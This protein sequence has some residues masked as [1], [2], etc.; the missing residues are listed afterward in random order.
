MPD[1]VKDWISDGTPE[2]EPVTV[3]TPA[4]A[5]APELSTSDVDNVENTGATKE[6]VDETVVDTPVV[7]DAAA[8]IEMIAGKLG[9]EAYEI[10]AT[11]TIPL[12]HGDEIT[13]VSVADLQTGNMKDVDYR[14]KTQAI[15]DQRRELEAN[16]RQMAIDLARLRSDQAFVD[17]QTKEMKEAQ[18]DPTKWDAYQ[19]HL[20]MIGENPRYAKTFTDAQAQRGTEAELEVRRASDMEVAVN[21]GSAMAVGWIDELGARDEFKGINKERVQKIYSD[22]LVSGQAQLA[23]EAVLRIFEQ[24]ADYLKESVSPLQTQVTALTAQVEELRQGQANGQ[25]NATTEHAV[26]R[27]KTVPTITHGTPPGQVDKPKEKF[28][29]RELGQQNSAW[30]KAGQK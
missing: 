7:E 22:Q 6:L 2:T 24:E 28:H 10:P 25:H 4:I 1:P 21:E 23:P 29:M 14:Q 16:G 26:A 13:Y 18:A 15:A 8:A 30:I 5:P 17:E 20:R 19:E 9:E 3:E 27:A 11:A 12:K